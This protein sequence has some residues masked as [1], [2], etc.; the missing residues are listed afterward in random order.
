MRKNECN[1][2]SCRSKRISR[3]GPTTSRGRWKRGASSRCGFPITATFPLR[4]DIKGEDIAGGAADLRERAKA[5][6]RDPKSIPITVFWAPEERATIDSWERAGVDRVIFGLPSAER[7]AMLPKLD[8]LA[9]FT[10]GR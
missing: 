5:A 10:Q 9:R 8:Q 2:R 3:C 6:G 1:T 4:A 7:D